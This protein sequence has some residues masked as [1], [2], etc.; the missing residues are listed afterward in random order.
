MIE[1]LLGSF[2]LYTSPK[3]TDFLSS[4]HWCMLSNRIQGFIPK[5][6]AFSGSHSN[7]AYSA[8]AEYEEIAM[9]TITA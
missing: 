2:S 8:C 1:E 7:I 9:G 6:G 3:I 5:M 4:L